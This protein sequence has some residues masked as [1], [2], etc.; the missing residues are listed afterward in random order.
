MAKG[1]RGTRRHNL[2]VIRDSR[3]RVVASSTGRGMGGN[4]PA[5]WGIVRGEMTLNVGDIGYGRFTF[6]PGGVIPDGQP[7]IQPGDC[8][9]LGT[10]PT[11]PWVVF[12]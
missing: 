8:A 5:R 6:A 1:N 11:A 10:D 3:G 7:P 12:R 4:K 2:F 9:Y